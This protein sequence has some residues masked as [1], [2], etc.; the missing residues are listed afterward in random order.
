MV[1][2]DL[3]LVGA[4]QYRVYDVEETSE[5]WVCEVLVERPGEELGELHVHVQRLWQSA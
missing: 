4:L 5:P 3:L 2:L 1:V